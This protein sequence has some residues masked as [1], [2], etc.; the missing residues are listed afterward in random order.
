MELRRK[1]ELTVTPEQIEEFKL[2]YADHTISLDQ[3]AASFNMHPASVSGVA[4]RLGC[5]PRRPAGG[6]RPTTKP[7]Q[8]SPEEELQQIDAR[9]E[10]VLQLCAQRRVRAVVQ[11]GSTIVEVYGILP[12]TDP[13]LAHAH[14]WVRWM[15]LGGPEKIRTA[16]SEAKL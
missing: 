15:K 14:D 8:L 3:M 16:I 12:G 9:R 1:W 7:L 11:R 2:L 4:K 5:P 10:V 13:V 6:G